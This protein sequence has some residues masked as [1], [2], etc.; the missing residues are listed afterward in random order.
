MV[1]TESVL[2][3]TRLSLTRRPL[4]TPWTL[5]IVQFPVILFKLTVTFVPVST[6]SRLL[7][8]R[9]TLPQPIPTKVW[10]TLL[11]EGMRR[12]L[13]LTCYKPATMLIATLYLFR[14]PVEQLPVHLTTLQIVGLIRMHLS[15]VV[16]PTWSILSLLPRLVS[17]LSRLR[18]LKFLLIVLRVLPFDVCRD[19]AALTVILSSLKEDLG[20]RAYLE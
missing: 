2:R 15:L 11:V 16:V 3:P 10:E 17:P 20:R 14:S 5:L 18:W 1:H 9:R 12:L 13:P 4:Q 7:G 6:M 8:C 19:I